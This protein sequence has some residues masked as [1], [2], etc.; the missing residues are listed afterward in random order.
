MLWWFNISEKKYHYIAGNKQKNLKE[1]EK[2]R[3]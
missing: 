3:T 2:N 1:Y